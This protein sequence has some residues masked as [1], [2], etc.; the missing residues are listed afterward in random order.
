[1]LL[2]ISPT[3]KMGRA[4]QIWAAAEKF[5]MEK[6]NKPFPDSGIET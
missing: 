4:V 3:T 1:M 5:E 2:V 6:F